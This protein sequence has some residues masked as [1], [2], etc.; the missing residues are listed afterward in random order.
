MNAVTYLVQITLTVI[1]AGLP[2]WLCL[3]LIGDTN[4]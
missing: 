2:W 4:E 3:L 1:I